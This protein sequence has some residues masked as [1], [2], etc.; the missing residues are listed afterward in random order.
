MDRCFGE[1]F[2][3]YFAQGIHHVTLLVGT[4]V[5]WAAI[6]VETADVA[7]ADGVGVVVDAVCTDL[8]QSSAGTDCAV[9][10]DNIV[11]ATCT[12]SA[13]TMPTVNLLDGYVLSFFCGAAM[14][15]DL[16]YISHNGLGVRG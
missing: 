1:L 2:Q 4:G 7:D 16:I 6:A 15:Y 14:Q 8:T 10:I 12:E 5:L 11:V 3:E 9:A 13:L